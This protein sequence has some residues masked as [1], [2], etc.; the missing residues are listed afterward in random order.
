M[1]GVASKR[2]LIDVRDREEI[3]GGCVKKLEFLELISPRY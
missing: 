1:E 3:D 2:E